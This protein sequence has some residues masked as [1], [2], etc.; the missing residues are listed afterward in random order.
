MANYKQREEEK[1]RRRAEMMAKFP[2]QNP[3]ENVSTM[4]LRKDVPA[5]SGVSLG[6]AKSNPREEVQPA[7]N[8][9][10]NEAQAWEPYPLKIEPAIDRPTHD[11][12]Y[13]IKAAN[14]WKAYRTD[15]A[16]RAARLK[17]PGYQK[18]RSVSGYGEVDDPMYKPAGNWSVNE[19]NTFGYLYGQNKQSAYDYAKTIN[20]RLSKQMDEIGTSLRQEAKEQWGKTADFWEDV[21]DTHTKAQEANSV[22]NRESAEA[23]GDM[24]RSVGDGIKAGAQASAQVEIARGTQAQEQVQGAMELGKKAW[25]YL[26]GNIGAINDATSSD[27]MGSGI[28]GFL[29][30]AS[31]DEQN[32]IE[33]VDKQK[34]ILAESVTDNIP[35][36]IGGAIGARLAGV[37]QPLDLVRS[38]WEF[39]LGGHVDLTGGEFGQIR[40]TIDD[41]IS[42]KLGESLPRVPDDV[43]YI[44]G[45]GA[46]DIYEIITSGVDDAIPMLMKNGALY[47]SISEISQN[48][49]TSL[50]EAKRRWGDD[51]LAMKYATFKTI[52]TTLSEI[53]DVDELNFGN[54]DDAISRI[55]SSG[56][57]N[58]VIE[59]VSQVG[60]Q[61][62][63][64]YSSWSID[65]QSNPRRESEETAETWRDGMLSGVVSGST[66]EVIDLIKAIIE[67]RKEKK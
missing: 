42:N 36:M 14:G 25:E 20:T 5:A 41:A 38:G 2:S 53:M 63:D 44:G 28:Y 60:G 54:A 9:S 24:W 15:E 30:S 12:A 47:G 65:N 67:K 32:E 13:A 3:R 56:L 57:N 23:I 4:L 19:N 10:V 27:Q 49:H 64:G 43:L 7:I 22:A 46:D 51:K 50:E 18:W 39:G 61:L 40:S 34:E 55:L 16:N 33:N 11:R 1:K 35:S 58:G 26:Q 8:R 6:V 29:K 31:V 52:G 17:D 45:M 37:L 62:A 66:E 48:F 59:I 21:W